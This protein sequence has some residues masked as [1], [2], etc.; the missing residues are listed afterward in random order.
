MDIAIYDGFIR[1]DQ[2]SAL[3]YYT[4]SL[5]NTGCGENFYDIKL[6]SDFTHFMKTYKK[7]VVLFLKKLGFNSLLETY[8][9]IFSFVTENYGCLL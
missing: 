5:F 6:S 8:N 9:L 7:T 3:R 2:Y 4:D 1:S